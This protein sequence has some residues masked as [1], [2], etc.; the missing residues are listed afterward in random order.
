MNFSEFLE[1]VEQPAYKVKG[2][3]DVCPKGHRLDPKTGTCMP[4]GPVQNSQNPD[5]KELNPPAS[6]YNV[7]GATGLNGDGYALEEKLTDLTK[8]MRYDEN[9]KEFKKVDDRMKYGRDGKPS[10][11]LGKGEVKKFN[12]RTGKWESNK[13]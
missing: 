7:W 5:M 2:K 3:G 13:K 1:A 8:F 10:D 11:E 4:I 12:K 6:G 9:E